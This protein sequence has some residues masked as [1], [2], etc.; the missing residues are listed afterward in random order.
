MKIKDILKNS[1]QVFSEYRREFYIY[2]IVWTI[3]LAVSVMLSSMYQL[4]FLVIFCVLFPMQFAFDFIA[5]KASE[6]IALKE[7]DFYF[8]FKK[9]LSSV[10]FGSKMAVKGFIISF[11]SFVAFTLIASIG[12]AFLISAWEPGLIEQLVN[13]SANLQEVYDQIM[14]VGWI[15]ELGV[16]TSVAGLAVAAVV[17]SLVGTNTNLAPLVCFD[18]PFDP[19]SGIRISREINSHN[20]KTFMKLNLLFLLF[21]IVAV[22]LGFGLYYLL[23]GYAV[24]N[25]IIALF[26]A[27]LLSSILIA[28]INI[29]YHLAKYQYYMVY[30]RLEVN[31]IIEDLKKQQQKMYENQK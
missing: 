26:L 18:A 8:G 11:L 23:F 9:F 25:E 5:K 31:K 21:L 6:H 16:I 2:S 17:Y 14:Q 13:S 19:D 22:G 30:G 10:I 12:V 24:V 1:L 29:I 4:T 28:P 20:K 15:V 3:L 27:I 7:N